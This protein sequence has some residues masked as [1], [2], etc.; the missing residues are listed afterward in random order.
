MIIVHYNMKKSG[1]TGGISKCQ[2]YL[3]L[4]KNSDIRAH[5]AERICCNYN[6][7]HPTPLPKIF[8]SPSSHL[9]TPSPFPPFLSSIDISLSFPFSP[10]FQYQSFSIDK[11]ILIS[12]YPFIYIHIHSNFPLF[13]L[14]FFISPIFTLYILYNQT[15]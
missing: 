7:L 4:P 10:S 11:Y 3:T 12:T 5:Q 8:P 6:T 9:P 1:Q 13:K 14:S 15:V 2:I